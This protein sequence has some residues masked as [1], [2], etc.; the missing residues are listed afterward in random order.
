MWFLNLIAQQK[1]TRECTYLVCRYVTFRTV[2]CYL[3][4]AVHTLHTAHERQLNRKCGKKEVI[5]FP[6]S[7]WVQSQQIKVYGTCL[8]F[9]DIND[10]TCKLRHHMSVKGNLFNRRYSYDFVNEYA[11]I[12]EG[13]VYIRYESLSGRI[14]C[15]LCCTCLRT[16]AGVN[17]D[18]SVGMVTVCRQQ[19]LIRR[20]EFFSLPTRLDWLGSSPSVY[21]DVFHRD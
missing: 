9:K 19:D 15:V 6:S 7:F 5:C 20:R 13:K 12:D 3:V 4:G 1:S 16:H 10:E 8:I 11:N 2:V 17:R 18:S 21:R 14:T